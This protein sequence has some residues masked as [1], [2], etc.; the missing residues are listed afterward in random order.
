MYI[1]CACFRNGYKHT[2]VRRSPKGG[3]KYTLT[4]TRIRT[5]SVFKMATTKIK[6]IYNKITALER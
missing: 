6:T 5:L 1:A 3:H 4:Y 2:V